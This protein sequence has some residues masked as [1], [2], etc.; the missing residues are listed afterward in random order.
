M[1]FSLLFVMVVHAAGCDKY[2][3]TD[4][5]PTVRLTAPWIVALVV[6]FT[7][8]ARHRS[9]ASYIADDRDLCLPHL[10]SMPPLGVLV[11]MLP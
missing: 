1:F 8:P 6:L 5:S 9:I 4:A 7:G 10:Y 3:F 2:S 11:G